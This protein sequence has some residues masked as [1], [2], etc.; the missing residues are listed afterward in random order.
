MSESEKGILVRMDE[1]KKGLVQQVAK[2]KGLSMNAFI[3]EAIDVALDIATKETIQLSRDKEL[4]QH[5][6]KSLE[7]NKE[8][9]LKNYNEDKQLIQQKIE[10]ID[11]T[12]N[13]IAVENEEKSE[14]DN[15]ER[16]V[17]LVYRGRKINNIKSQIKDHAEKYNMDVDNLR[18]KILKDVENKKY[19]N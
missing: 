2:Y 16:L 1:H 19:A 3:N 6:L 13:N 15:Y 8:I 17:N 10:R 7:E 14:K 4:L 11:S 12:I 9:Y 5:E 18:M